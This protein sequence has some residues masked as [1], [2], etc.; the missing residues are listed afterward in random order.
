MLLQLFRADAVACRYCAEEV[1]DVGRVMPRY[2]YAFVWIGMNFLGFSVQC[3]FEFRS[4]CLLNKFFSLRA[5]MIGVAIV[6]LLYVI[7]PLSPTYIVTPPTCSYVLMNIAY[8]ACLSPVDMA[9]S[10][11]VGRD[12][13]RCATHLRVAQSRVLLSLRLLMRRR[14]AVVGEAGAIIIPLIVAIRFSSRNVTPLTGSVCVTL[15]PSAP[16]AAAMAPSSQEQES[17]SRLRGTASCQVR[18]C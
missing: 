10:K 12:A 16:S 3:V 14:S 8:I 9:E 4:I 2:L 5:N 18:T 17:Y 6:I 7:P 1:I 13:A 15:H 11:A